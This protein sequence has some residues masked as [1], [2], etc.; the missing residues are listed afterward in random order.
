MKTARLLGVALLSA[1]ALAVGGGDCRAQQAEAPALYVAPD[2]SDANPGTKARPFATLE[3][4]RDALRAAGQPGGATVWVKGGTYT[5]LKGL[6]LEAQDSGTEGSPVVYRSWGD[7]PVRLQGGREIPAP[8]FQPVAGEALNR[9]PQEARGKVLAADL[10]TLGI[11]G[12]GALPAKYR[13]AIPSPEVFF[14]DR[15]MT[16]ARWPN[17]GWATIHNVIDRGGQYS[18]HTMPDGKPD[19]GTFEYADPRPARWNVAK[20]VW[21]HGYW[22]HD[23]A[24]EVLRVRS[25]DTEKKQI[26]LAAAHGYGIGASHGWNKVP[27]RYYALNLLEELDAP[28]EWYLDAEAGTLYFWPPAGLASAR[29]VISLLNDPILTLKEASHVTLRGLTFECC[30]GDAVQISGGAGNLVAACVIRNTGKAAVGV[31]GTNNGVKGCDITLTGAGGISLNGGDRAKITPAGNY[32]DNNHVHHYARRARTYAPAIG[33]GGV[34]N[35]AT[36]NLIHDCPHSGILYGGNEHL[37]EF[38]DIFNTCLETGDAGALYT[39]RDW[40]SQGNA[41]RHNF[42]HHNGGVGGW[43]MGVYLDDCDSGDT[44]IGNVFYRV[45]R[46]AFIGGGRNNVVDNNVF[47]DCKPAVHVDDR[48]TSRIQW[49]AGLKESWDL[50]AKLK[51]LNYQSPPWSEK[52][53]HLVNILQ[54]QPAL[55]L[56]NR[57]T[58]NVAVGGTWLAARGKTQELLAMEGNVVTDEDPGFANPAKLDFRL[59]KDSRVWK[60]SPKFEA[61]PVEKIGLYRDALRASWP[62][63]VPALE[64]GLAAKEPEKPAVAKQNLPTHK[65]VKAPAGIDV[66]GKIGEEEWIAADTGAPVVVAKDLGGGA[67]KPASRALLMAGKDGLFV[68]FDNEVNPAKPLALGSTW[69]K[70]DA[71]EIAIRAPGK[72]PETLV[73]RGFPGGQWEVSD[74]AGA[75]AAT[76]ARAKEGVRYA[77]Q[78]VDAKRW[79]AEWSIPWS[80]LGIANPAGL[81]IPFNLAVRKTAN[82][83]WILWQGTEGYTWQVENAG[84]LQLP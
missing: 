7:G 26:S 65:V 8:A 36:H 75:P 34:G 39:G 13:G 15:P 22:C 47:V 31:S 73:F 37:I 38:N 14:Q 81:K 20:G 71:V 74:E 59:R 16:L 50:E 57:V 29:V 67:V 1:A 52:Y 70:C 72:K 32:A 18:T 43:S 9:I 66:D 77:A 80:A 64:G 62:V 84:F 25:I 68:A 30:Q 53:P 76:L 48:G 28:G 49:N 60:E 63:A 2:G 27:R 61:I 83:Q 45:A 10:K 54:D 5:C 17:E 58:R 82:D 41:I 42:I 56:H 40:S 35:R 44:I 6:V 46:A 21:L 11:T 12:F 78:V 4:A 79:T 3:R 24:D 33:L 51:A 19:N 23:W 55:P 69:G